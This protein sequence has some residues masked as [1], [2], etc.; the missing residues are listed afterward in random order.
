M[1]RVTH[2]LGS[3]GIGGMERQLLLYQRGIERGA[4]V[5]DLILFRDGPLRA[6]FET[7]MPT[8]TLDKRGKID[9]SFLTKL[10]S[11]LRRSRP[12]IVHAWGPTPSVWGPPAAK[13]ARVPHLVVSEGGIDVWKGRGR[14]WLDRRVAYM[15]DAV[16][17]NARAV[18][19][20]AAARGV[21]RERLHVV[22]NVVEGAPPIDEAQREPGLIVQLGRVDARKGH[23]VLVRALP[24]IVSAVPG[25]RLMFAGAAVLKDEI[26]YKRVVETLIDDLSVRG[27]I[28]F[29]GAYE[30][31]A[32]LLRRASVAVT[33]SRSEGLPNTLLEAMMNGAPVVATDVGGN[34]EA[35]THR[36]TG[37]LVRPDDPRALASAVVEVLTRPDAAAERARRARAV[38]EERFSIETQGRAW[39]TLYEGVA[40]DQL[41]R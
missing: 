8:T 16:V 21:P 37:L 4:V 2:L 10:V 15:S 31:A 14:S 35:V 40:G 24:H 17:G 33:P 20:A 39:M 23:D 30:E 41:S 18:V 7:A 29:F 12:D 36:Q 28:E 32:P 26:A 19:D 27:L 3:A 13:L 11:T 6:R 22:Y 5:P 9:I 25:A 1:I 38:V 34:G